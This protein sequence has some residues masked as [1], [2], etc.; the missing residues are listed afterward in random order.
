MRR[1]SDRI[2]FQNRVHVAASVHVILQEKRSRLRAVMLYIHG[3]SYRA[4]SGNVYVGHIVA[5]YDVIVVTINYRLGLLGTMICFEWE[6][7]NTWNQRRWRINSATYMPYVDRAIRV[8]KMIGHEH[9]SEGRS[10]WIL[11]TLC[12]S[13][14][15]HRSYSFI[16]AT[17]Q[18][19][20]TNIIH[21]NVNELYGL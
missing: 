18:N 3:G 12:S 8:S 4:G 21:G 14:I 5:Q 10:C 11:R 17:C 1:P 19:A 6:I 13:F 20:R 7:N 15:I 16:N 9:C 2:V